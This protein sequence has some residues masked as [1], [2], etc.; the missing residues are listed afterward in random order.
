MTADAI[1]DIEPAGDTLADL[2]TPVPV[3]DLDV[4]ERNLTRWQDRCDRLGLANRPHIKTHKLPYFARRQVALGAVGLTCQK[5]GEAEIMADVCK[6]IFITYNIVG[7]RKLARLSDLARRVRL[8]VVADFDRRRRGSWPGGPGRVCTDR[9]R[10]RMRHGCGP[11][12]S[13]KPSGRRRAGAVHR[14]HARPELLRPHDLSEAGHAGRNRRLPVGSQGRVRGAIAALPGDFD[15]RQPRYVERRRARHRQRIPGGHLYLQRP[16]ARHAWRLQNR[17][18]RPFSPDDGRQP[19]DPGP[20]DC[21]CRQQIA[22]ERSPWAGGLRIGAEMAQSRVARLDEE[23]GYLDLAEDAP[24]P[25]I[26]DRLSIIPNHVCVVVNL[27]DKV[28]LVRG[29]RVLGG[30]RVEARGKTT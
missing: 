25:R 28:I 13:A 27:F 22:D 16:L 29:N 21:R 6:D 3:I 4:A 12:R 19:A 30:L 26:G 8:S 9:G 14:R 15:R 7:D 1:D 17:R 23:H 18:L 24:G 5:V 2:E 20:S 10:G 11:L